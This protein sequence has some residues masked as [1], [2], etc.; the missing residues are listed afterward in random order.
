[1]NG[2]CRCSDCDF[3]IIFHLISLLL[4]CFVH[5]HCHVDMGSVKTEED[6][7]ADVDARKMEEGDHKMEYQQGESSADGQASAFSWNGVHMS[8]YNLY[9]RKNFPPLIK[10]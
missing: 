5:L 7:T 8:R 3:L 2:S 9:R 1:M 4:S 6:P 10:V